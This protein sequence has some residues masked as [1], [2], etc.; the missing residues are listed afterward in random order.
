MLKRA[1]VRESI[2]PRYWHVGFWAVV[3][4]FGLGSVD[5]NYLNNVGNTP[6]LKD[7]WYLA[8]LVPLACGVMVT[9]GCGGARL[10]KRIVAATICGIALG[11]LYVA[12]SALLVKKMDASD[13]AAACAWRAFVFAVL[14]T[15]GAIA[16]ELKLPEPQPKNTG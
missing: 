9:L 2:K 1:E 10:W 15:V 13:I 14:S 3:A 5:Y 11:V 16:T 7:I 6:G 4:A 8:A 12:V